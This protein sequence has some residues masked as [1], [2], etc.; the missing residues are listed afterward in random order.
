MIAASGADASN[1]AGSV[2]ATS[3]EYRFDPERTA[4]MF[5]QSLAALHRLP[6]PDDAG[7]VTAEDVLVECRAHPPS[8]EDLDEAY[9]HMTPQRLLEILEQTLPTG[10]APRTLTHGNATLA[11]LRCRD[12]QAVGFADWSAAAVGDPHRDLASAAT[13]VASHLGPMAVPL[14][15]SAYGR[16][17]E[18][19]RLEWWTLALQ[20][21]RRP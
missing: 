10:P 13:S 16:D 9:S 1:T 11:T 2:A 20:L 19:L 3:T 21:G 18:P 5:G 7:E 8:A 14:M 15:F 4:A 12:G 6:V 17:P